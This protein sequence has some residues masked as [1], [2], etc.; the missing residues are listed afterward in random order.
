MA[1]ILVN[2]TS[3]KD[4]L[5]YLQEPSV[6]FILKG[7]KIQYTFCGDQATFLYKTL[8]ANE[9]KKK[10]LHNVPGFNKIFYANLLSHIDEVLNT[11]ASYEQSYLQ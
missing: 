3:A 8:A 2:Q 11:V 10:Y 4:T 6:L 5:Y 1:F 9:E 7:S